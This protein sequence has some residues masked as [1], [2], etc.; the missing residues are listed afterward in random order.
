MKPDLTQSGLGSL[1]QAVRSIM[2]GKAV[3]ID[4][5]HDTKAYRTRNRADGSYEIV[6]QMRIKEE[7]D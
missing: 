3:K 7:E 1:A 6:I 2:S 5:G 4:L